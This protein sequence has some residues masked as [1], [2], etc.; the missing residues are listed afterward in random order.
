MG[1]AMTSSSVR[2]EWT[3][4]IRGG[5][6]AEGTR[7]VGGVEWGGRA[8]WLL[9]AQ[10]PQSPSCAAPAKFWVL[11]NHC[12]SREESYTQR[13]RARAHTH[14]CKKL[15]DVKRTGRRPCSLRARRAAR[16]GDSE[17]HPAAFGSRALC[18]LWTE[19]FGGFVEGPITKK[20]LE[21]TAW[22]HREWAL[23]GWSGHT[24]RTNCE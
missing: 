17:V 4:A 14:T 3:N 11:I 9:A 6:S 18:C 12:R 20:C 19:S 2:R 5:Q 8:P 16:E 21:T 1:N 15:T 7:D 13:T 24:D 23:G 10:R 22:T